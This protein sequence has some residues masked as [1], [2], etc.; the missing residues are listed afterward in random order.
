[1]ITPERR[2]IPP[3]GRFDDLFSLSI[4]QDTRPFSA[5]NECDSVVAIN[6]MHVPSTISAPVPID[7]PKR[8]LR[9]PPAPRPR[10]SLQR[11]GAAPAFAEVQEGLGGAED[12]EADIDEDGAEDRGGDGG[13]VGG[14]FLGAHH[15]AGVCL[16]ASQLATS[17]N[18]R[19]EMV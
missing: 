15:G 7:P 10:R 9:R 6:P 17:R 19:W 18:V 13:V 8:L 1:M 5:D 12:E 3:D 14:I 2:T 4:T 11:D 16:G